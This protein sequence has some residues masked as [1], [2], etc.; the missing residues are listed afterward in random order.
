MTNRLT[1]LQQA[2]SDRVAARHA[3]M[4]SR[5]K[6][7]IRAQCGG[8]HFPWDD[9]PRC[10]AQYKRDFELPPETELI[11]RVHRR[12]ENNLPV[13]VGVPLEIALASAAEIAAKRSGQL[14]VASDQSETPK[15][16]LY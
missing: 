1:P 16:P 8:R 11:G 15:T 10:I 12:F 13:D 9:L 2:A 7:L 4:L 3:E 5:A 14:P 6:I